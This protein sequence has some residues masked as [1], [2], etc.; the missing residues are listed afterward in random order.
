MHNDYTTIGFLGA[1]DNRRWPLFKQSTEVVLDWIFANRQNI[2][3][4]V[5]YKSLPWYRMNCRIT[6][7][8]LDVCG[9]DYIPWRGWNKIFPSQQGCRQIEAAMVDYHLIDRLVGEGHNYLRLV[10]R[11]TLRE[12]GCIDSVIKNSDYVVFCDIKYGRRWNLIKDICRL[13]HIPLYDVDKISD[14]IV[15]GVN[16]EASYT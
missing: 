7:H 3:T 12:V 1:F 4:L 5:E 6:A 15:K 14:I 9:V 2:H 13:R 16:N 10:K 8:G 11:G